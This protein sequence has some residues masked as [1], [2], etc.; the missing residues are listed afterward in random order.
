MN[1]FDIIIKKLNISDLDAIKIKKLINDKD[2]QTDILFSIDRY[3]H[4]KTKES[5]ELF[6]FIKQVGSEF[7]VFSEKGKNFGCYKSENEAKK[8]LAQIKRFGSS[9]HIE[10]CIC[11]MCLEGKRVSEKTLEEEEQLNNI[12]IQEWLGFSYRDYLQSILSAVEMDDFNNLRALTSENV[13]A[14]YLDSKQIARLKGVLRQSFSEGVNMREIAR[15]IE[16]EVRPGNLYQTDDDGVM[17]LNADGNPILQVGAERRPIAIARS[18]TTRMAAQGALNHYKD[19]GI[20]KYSWI[21]SISSRTCEICSN[22]NGQIFEIGNG[23]LPGDPHSMCRC[24]IGAYVP[25]LNA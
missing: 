9:E 1:L 22:L 11:E 20:E 4:I 14:G 17:K 15:R 19:G 23:P 6:E 8:R 12:N 18:E 7:C 3:F 5:F 24:T 13:Q 25:G 21:A 16:N 10:N 2:D